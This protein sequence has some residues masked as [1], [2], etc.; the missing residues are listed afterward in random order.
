MET[1][2]YM[3]DRKPG[4][5]RADSFRLLRV[6]LLAMIFLGTGCASTP[7]DAGGKVPVEE[8]PGLA[9][10][11]EIAEAARLQSAGVRWN[12]H[13]VTERWRFDGDQKP[14]LLIDGWVF[15][16]DAIRLRLTA[17]AQLNIFR[18]R[19]HSVVVKILQLSDR[20][21]FSDSRKT[22]LGLQ[23]I[24][25]DPP[26]DASV[27]AAES[28]VLHPG[29]DLLLSLNRVANARFVA[30]VAGYFSL[31]GKTT[32]RLIPMPVIAA[33]AEGSGILGA[34]SFGVLGEEEV[35]PPRP[36]GLKILLEL[37]ADTIEN[38]RVQAH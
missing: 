29:A 7:P 37:G 1:A 27:V 13:D 15:E 16:E 8:D 32:T 28:R 12:W 36:A 22:A 25:A 6:A 20:Q 11:Q 33:Q 30:L 2:N 35:P 10:D 17:P 24:L 31:D 26:F 19:P 3:V 34:L 38:V 14:D 23:K 5:G 18:Q 21:P 9:A 4:A